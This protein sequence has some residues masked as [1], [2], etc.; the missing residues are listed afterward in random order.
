MQNRLLI[1]L[2]LPVLDVCVRQ[3]QHWS[4]A[5]HKI[6]ALSVDRDAR[7]PFLE[8]GPALDAAF[9]RYLSENLPCAGL[10]YPD[11]LDCLDAEITVRLFNRF[12]QAKLRKLQASL[13]LFRA[14]AQNSIMRDMDQVWPDASLLFV[15]HRLDAVRLGGV[16]QNSAEAVSKRFRA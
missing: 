3:L 9:T 10:Q 8:Q 16:N 14:P 13:H 15:G 5:D 11:L 4:H 12:Q 7:R 2:A 1:A 6:L